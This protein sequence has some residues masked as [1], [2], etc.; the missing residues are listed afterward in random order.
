MHSSLIELLTSIVPLSQ[1]EQEMIIGAFKEIHLPKGT[2]FLEEGATSSHVGFLTKGLVRYFVHKND[3]EATFEFTREG[4]FVADYQSFSKQI[5]SQQNI[6]AIE[7]CTMLIIGLN[8]LQHIFNNTTHGNLLGRIIIEHR[9]AIMVQQL[10]AIYM[11]SQEARYYHFMKEYPDLVQ[12]IPLYLIASYVGIQP[13]SLSRIR[14]KY[15]RR[16]S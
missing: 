3:Q 2:L 6:Q 15:Q 1:K 14:R 9:F 13:Q 5:P 11:Q 7:D 12:R 8:E 16:F 10:L 4:E